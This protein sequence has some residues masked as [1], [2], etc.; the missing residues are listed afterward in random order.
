MTSLTF[1]VL[2]Y[3]GRV[4]SGNVWSLQ[5]RRILREQGNP[6]WQRAWTFPP[7]SP[8]LA[9]MD[10]FVWPQVAKKVP[11]CFSPC[12]ILV[13]SFLWQLILLFK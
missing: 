13:N 11:I 1:Q 5:A 10:F 3:L 2:T 7:Y 8:D 12:G 9:L 6:Q 4:F